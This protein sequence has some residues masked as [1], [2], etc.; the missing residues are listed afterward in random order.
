VE[1]IKICDLEIAPSIG[2]FKEF[3][4]GGLEVLVINIEGEFFCTSARCP[5][6]GGAP[7]AEG[8]LDGIVLTCPWH[9]AQFRVTDGKLLRGPAK[10]DLRVYQSFVKEN[11][12]FI[13]E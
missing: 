3:K 5:H 2:S 1:L 6:A 9:E 12:I 13:E 8:T 11:S 4:V 10:E 7:L